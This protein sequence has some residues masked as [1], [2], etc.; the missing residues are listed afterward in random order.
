MQDVEGAIGLEFE[1]LPQRV[2]ADIHRKGIDARIPK[3]LQHEATRGQGHFA[4]GGGTAHQY[5]DTA[6]ATGYIRRWHQA[7]HDRPSA[8]PMM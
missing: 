5:R 1:D 6:T 3:R 7:A 2:V 4:L 8:S